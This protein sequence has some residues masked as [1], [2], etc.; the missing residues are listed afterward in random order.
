MIAVGSDHAGFEYKE[1]IK[2]L[3]ADMGQEVRDV[4][5]ASAAS[6][7]YPDWAHQVAL[8]VAHG[9]C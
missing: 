9:E 3:L 8:L 5:A 6:S 4:G 2:K 7:D 1:R